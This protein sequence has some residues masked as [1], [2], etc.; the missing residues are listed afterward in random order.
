MTYSWLILCYFCYSYQEYFWSLSYRL[1]FCEKCKNNKKKTSQQKLSLAEK[2]NH[3][4]T[5]IKTTMTPYLSLLICLVSLPRSQA[6]I[7]ACEVHQDCGNSNQCET[8]NGGYCLA[9]LT[10]EE[11]GEIT[12]LMRC[13]DTSLAIPP[14]QPF[15]CHSR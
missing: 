3:A 11:N 2:I 10:L 15:M 1:I 8:D 12:R 5:Q 6:L 14:G 7:C 4:K 9:S 13:L